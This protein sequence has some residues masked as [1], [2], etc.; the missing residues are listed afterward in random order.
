MGSGA[1]AQTL[2]LSL[3]RDT[4]RTATCPSVHLPN[5]LASTREGE[6]R[7]ACWM[8]DES[9]LPDRAAGPSHR[10]H[11]CAKEDVS[12]PPAPFQPSLTCQSAAGI[13][14]VLP[15]EDESFPPVGIASHALP[16][17]R[18]QPEAR[19]TVAC[20][21]VHFSNSLASAREGEA[22]PACWMEDESFPPDRAVGLSHLNH[23]CATEDVSCPPAPFQPSLACKP[24]AGISSVLPREDES[25]PP[26]GT[27]SHALPKDRGRPDPL[28]GLAGPS[29]YRTAASSALFKHFCMTEDASCPPA[30]V[31]PSHICQTA[32]GVSSALSREEE[33]FPLVGDARHA[34]PKGHAQP[35]LLSRLAGPSLY[36]TEP[37]EPSSAENDPGPGGAFSGGA[38]GLG[39]PSSS[40]DAPQ[41]D[42]D[43]LSWGSSRSERVRLAPS[44]AALQPEVPFE[45]V[46]FDI[47]RSLGPLPASREW[48]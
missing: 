26:V 3:L 30:P 6:A 44:L 14:S 38:H 40:S 28:A 18:G 12:F 5:G 43:E 41:R 29:L 48:A 2:P 27:A 35:D 36:G 19:L 1:P 33:S 13:S 32:A 20:P 42:P 25:F 22:C 31:Q 47:V 11:P 4:Q 9:F 37:A 16:K 24:A 39:P 10:R 15:R 45:F 34:F 46:T 23:A 17:D 7:L 8:E 21:S